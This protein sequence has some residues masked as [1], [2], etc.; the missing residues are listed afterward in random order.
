MDAKEQAELFNELK[1]HAPKDV[2]KRM[3][4]SPPPAWLDDPEIPDMVK[5]VY[6]KRS[7]VN[8]NLN[9]PSGRNALHVN[10]IKSLGNNKVLQDATDFSA[11][12]R[13]SA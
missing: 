10:P 13:V 7:D 6:N 1:K 3:D 2:R 11:S 5:E 4:G 9:I 8:K 12:N